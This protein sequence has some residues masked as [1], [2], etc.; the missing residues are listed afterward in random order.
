MREFRVYKPTK[1]KT[2][3]AASFQ[4]SEKGK[5][6]EPMVFLTLAKQGPDD[7]KGNNGFSWKDREN[8]VTAKLSELDAAKMLLVLLGMEDE[9][10]LFHDPSKSGTGEANQGASKV[11]NLIKAENGSKYLSVSLKQGEKLIK[12]QVTLSKDEQVLL[13]IFLEGFIRKYYLGD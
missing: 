8:S 4:I 6:K 11:V 7:D 10:K 2:G 12:I 13:K 1:A 9:A 3:S 5:Y